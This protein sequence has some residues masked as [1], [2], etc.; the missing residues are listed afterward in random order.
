LAAWFYYGYTFLDSS[1]L[2]PDRYTDLNWRITGVSGATM[3]GSKV[4]TPVLS[5]AG[6]TYSAAQSVSLSVAT[7]GATIR[8]TT[9]GSVPTLNSPAYTGPLT[10]DAAATLRARAFKSGWIASDAALAAYEFQVAEVVMPAGGLFSNAQVVALSTPTT[11]AAIRYTL[12]GTDPTDTS[13]LY[14]APMT[15]DQNGTLKARAFKTG[16]LRD[17]RLARNVI[18]NASGHGGHFDVRVIPSR[19]Q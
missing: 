1:Y 5:P 19:L 7:E 17:G 11:G 4:E 12:D 6:G 3:I 14:G 8:Y 13:P 15:V 10:V 16:W 9:D 18:L 2:T